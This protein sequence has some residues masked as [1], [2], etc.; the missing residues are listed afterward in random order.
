VVVL[1]VVLEHLF[2]F[3]VLEVADEIIETEFFS[4]F[5]TVNEPVEER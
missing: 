1:W 4:P 3:W 5:L 2:L